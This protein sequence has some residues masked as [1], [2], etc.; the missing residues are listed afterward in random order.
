MQTGLPSRTARA[1]AFHR[2]AHQVLENGR[3]FTDP[4]ALRI[5]GTSAEE[6]AQEAAQHPSGR[7]MRLFIA[8]R[9]RRAEDTLHAAIERGVRQMV[10]LGAGLDT[11]AYRGAARDCVRIFE[12][13]HPATQAWKRERLAEASIA[14]PAGLTFAPLDFERQ[15]LAEGLADAGFDPAR[16]TFF[17]W[18]GVVPYLTEDATW[19]TLAF[20]GSLPGGGHVV[21]DYSD[22]PASLAPEARV[23]H[24]N[25]AARVAELGEPWI[26]YFEPHRLHARLMDLGFR[27]VEDWGPQQI[28]AHFFPTRVASAPAAG[29]H[30]LYA[31]SV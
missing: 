3:I 9:T 19:S 12:V 20:I 30:V 21:F 5:L 22:P 13:D 14:L 25:R 6:V 15:T 4:L 7:R 24:D 18:L 27:E 2:A 8:V 11:Y 23:S 10:V 17:I 26:A 1:A 28:A 29:G 16:Q 31:A